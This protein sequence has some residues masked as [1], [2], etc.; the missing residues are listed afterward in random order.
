MSA[1]CLSEYRCT[2]TKTPLSG[3]LKCRLDL[4]ITSSVVVLLHARV[5]CTT[6]RLL[7]VPRTGFRLSWTSTDAAFCRQLNMHLDVLTA[8]KLVAGLHLLELKPASKTPSALRLPVS[9]RTYGTVRTK[10]QDLS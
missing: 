1:F 2:L 6:P 10:M 4:K 7:R 5:R 3:M 9:G 8:P